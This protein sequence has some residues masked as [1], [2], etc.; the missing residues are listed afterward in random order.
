MQAFIK[1]SLVSVLVTFIACNG[2]EKSGSLNDKKK[3]TSGTKKRSK[4]A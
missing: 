4:C 3:Q 1:I 2:T